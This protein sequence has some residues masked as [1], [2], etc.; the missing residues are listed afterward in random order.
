MH[1][2]LLRSW[3]PA[4]ETDILRL[5]AESMGV[6]SPMNGARFAKLR[7]RCC[8]LLVAEW[9]AAVVGFL[10]GFGDGTGYDSGNYRWFAARLKRFLYID[11]VVVA[12]QFRGT[13]VGRRF[14]AE[15]ERRAVECGLFWLAA[16]VDLRPPNTVSLRFHERL[17]FVEVGRR[18]ADNHKQVSLQVRSL[19]ESDNAL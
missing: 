19:C 15:A 6:L 14:Y 7:K 10:M 12:R 2:L 5:N 3:Q 9:K 13:G 11:R 17:A 1:G 18:A 4:D 8:I 16:E